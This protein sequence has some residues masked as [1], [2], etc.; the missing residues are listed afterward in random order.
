MRT[1]DLSFVID[2]PEATDKFNHFDDPSI[3]IVDLYFYLYGVHSK[4]FS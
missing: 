2:C 3:F 1:E 4:I